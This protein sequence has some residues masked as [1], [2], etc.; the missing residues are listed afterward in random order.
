[1]G[2]F[3]R[4]S[5]IVQA[6]IN[7]MLD[8]AEDPEKV[9]RLIIQE[10]EET[11]VEIRSVAAKNL[12]EQ[13]QLD[14]QI[15]GLQ[16]QASNWQQKAQLAVDKQRDDLA[17]AALTEKHSVESKVTALEEQKTQLDD[18]IKNIQED[19]AR[20]Q[21]KLNEARTKQKSLVARKQN[22]AVRLQ[23]KQSVNSNAVE[24][25]V[26]RFEQYESRVEALEAQVDA[27]D[28]VPASSETVN[29][30]QQFAQL[31]KDENVEAELA[32][33]KAKFK[34]PASKATKSNAKA[35]A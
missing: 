3:S 9:I 26:T 8:K 23:A 19:T 28:I 31:E 13:K 10:M 7:A 12:A 35:A 33:L 24:D 21:S 11:L 32:K 27:F 18:L 22:S 2:M 17:R 20:L 5:D 1:M 16:K 14:R 30:E 4:I 25:A 29:L 34:K 6:N 15:S